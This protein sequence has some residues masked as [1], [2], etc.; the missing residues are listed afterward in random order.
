MTLVQV[1]EL[2]TRTVKRTPIIRPTTGLVR[3]ALLWKTLPA[4]G[5]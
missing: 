2:W 1:D 4:H 5:K 3:R